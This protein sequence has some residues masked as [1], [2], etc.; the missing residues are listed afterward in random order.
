MSMSDQMILRGRVGTGLTLR[1]AEDGGRSFARFRMVV[2]RSRRK[3]DGGW[4]DGE[5]QWYTVRAWGSLAEHLSVSLHKGQPIIVIGRP[6]VQAWISREGEL[7]SELAVNAITA[8]HDL[9]MGVGMFSRLSAMIGGGASVGGA[10]FAQSSPLD[11]PAGSADAEDGPEDETETSEENVVCD[12]G[13]VCDQVNL[14][15]GE[16]DS[17]GTEVEECE[18]AA[19]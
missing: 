10:A 7:R 16:A 19:A 17:E 6:A 13:E 8:G 5:P 3:D 18:P 2:P 12:E 15:V 14:A 9:G 1:R 11:A 4:E